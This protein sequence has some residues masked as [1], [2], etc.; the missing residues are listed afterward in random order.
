MIAGVGTVRQVMKNIFTEAV[1][2]LD[3]VYGQNPDGS[4]DFSALESMSVIKTWDDWAALDIRSYDDFIHTPKER[5]R[6]PVVVVCADYDK[7]TIKRAVFPTKENIWRRDKY[8]CCYSGEKLTRQDLTVDHIVPQCAG[9]GDT[10]LNLVT[11][12]KSIN[13]AKGHKSLKEAKLKL[14]YPPFKPKFGYDHFVLDNFREE[15]QHFVS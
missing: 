5:I 10:W 12:K 7:I 8:I 4:V 2:P 11:C 15:W 3:L 14:K 13:H 1:Y 6:L 9:G